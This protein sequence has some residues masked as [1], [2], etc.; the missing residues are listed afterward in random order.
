MIYLE[1]ETIDGLVARPL[2][3]QRQ[4]VIEDVQRSFQSLMADLDADGKDS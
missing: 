2:M 4:D 1:A 3:V